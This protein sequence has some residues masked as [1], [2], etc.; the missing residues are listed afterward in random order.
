[1]SQ[2][3]SMPAGHAEPHGGGMATRL[4]WLL[5]GALIGAAGI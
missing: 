4:T 3:R 1:M 2:I 5:A